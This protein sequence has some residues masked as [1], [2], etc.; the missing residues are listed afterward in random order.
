MSLDKPKMSQAQIDAIM[1]AANAKENVTCEPAYKELYGDGSKTPKAIK[2]F[3]PPKEAH[4]P[5][6][7]EE[8]EKLKK[9]NAQRSKK[10]HD[11]REEERHMLDRFDKARCDGEYFAHKHKVPVCEK[12]LGDWWEVA[13]YGF[14]YAQQEL[15][16]AISL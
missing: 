8:V 6:A 4:P 10:Y 11:L 15:G 12:L 5:L 16:R 13:D 7:S 9:E 14:I 1:D 2:P 3:Q